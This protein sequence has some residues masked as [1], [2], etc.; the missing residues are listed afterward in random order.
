MQ[1][2]LTIPG[3]EDHQLVVDTGGFWSSAK[4]LIDGEPAPKGPKR[5]Q[6]ALQRLDGSEAV[7]H[8]RITNP[9]D[10]VP[11]V[12]IDGQA[13]TL[14]EPLKW[15]QW[16]WSGL[17]FVLV[18]I[19]GA[20]GGLFGGIALAVNG[21]V[22]RTKLNSLARY[23]LT[24]L[25]SLGA[26]IAYL[27]SATLF[28]LT[29]HGF[30]PKVAREFRSEAG[31]FSVQTPYTLKET[32]Q[33][34]DT[35][36]GKIEFHMFVGERGNESIM[37]GYSDYPVELMQTSNAERVLDGSRDGVVGNT[38]GELASEI[39]ISLDGYPGRELTINI[40][41]ENVQAMVMRCRFFLVQN[42]LYQ[43]VALVPK[44]KGNDKY[45]DD[46][47]QSFTLLDP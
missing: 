12:V 18:I 43:V 34:V 40:N 41:I 17:P 38:K 44:G 24:G 31:N 35:D 6:F 42:R 1:Y 16:L 8:F 28:N 22:F 15:Y 37:V 39:Q 14:T 21:R 19:G 45:I 7:A 33:L 32:S 46:F 30:A 26:V 27:I 47:L 2:S 23:S 29:I 20:L 9:L 25:I 13:F 36:V 4:L 3:F 10:P 5:G 11:Q